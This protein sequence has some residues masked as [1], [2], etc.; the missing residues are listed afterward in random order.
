MLKGLSADTLMNP[1]RL[2]SFVDAATRNLT[3]DQGLDVG[4]M[5]SLAFSLRNV[6]GRDI[7]FVTAPFTGFGTSPAGASTS[8]TT[9][10]WPRWGR[11]SL[12]TAWTPTPVEAAKAGKPLAFMQTRRNAGCI[13]RRKLAVRGTAG[14]SPYPLQA[15]AHHRAGGGARGRRLRGADGA[16]PEDVLGSDP[17]LHR[18]L[19]CRQ[20]RLS[21]AGQRLHPAAGQVVRPA[22]RDSQSARPRDRQAQARHDGGRA[23]R[24]RGRDRPAGYGPHRGHG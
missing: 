4:E 19:G 17:V 23:G 1:A 21:P 14:L 13:G 5:Q 11:Q 8:S 12:G 7:R 24:P 3:V 16:D 18:H 22:P 15:L 20:Q 2:A 6:G 10:R 9:E